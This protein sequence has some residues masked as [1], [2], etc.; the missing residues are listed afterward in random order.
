VKPY[1]LSHPD[2]NGL[3]VIYLDEHRAHMTK[4]A[5]AVAA[6]F[7]AVFEFIQ[8]VPLRMYNIGCPYAYHF[9]R[10]C[11]NK[12]FNILYTAGGYTSMLQPL[13][14]GPNKVLKDAL[15]AEYLPYVQ[16]HSINKIPTF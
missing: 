3:C 11:L 13:D 14:V 7:G 2:Y 8:G 1:L 9:L 10:S 4:E 5:H 15:R 6:S 16:Y 12:L